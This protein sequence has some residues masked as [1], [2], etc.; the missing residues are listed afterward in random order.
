MLE[1]ARLNSIKHRSRESCWNSW[2]TSWVRVNRVGNEAIGAHV[3][4]LREREFGSACSLHGVL[5]GARNGRLRDSSWGCRTCNLDVKSNRALPVWPCEY[6]ASNIKCAIE[7]IVYIKSQW[8]VGVQAHEGQNR[9]WSV[10]LIT[11]RYQIR[12]LW[13]NIAMPLTCTRLVCS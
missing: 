12:A 7:W 9:V 6:F 13:S 10:V 3:L 2:G 8:E 11:K 5:L 4:K 1:R